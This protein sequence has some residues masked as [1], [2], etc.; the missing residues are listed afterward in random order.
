MRRPR[1][2]SSHTGSI[3]AMSGDTAGRVTHPHC[4]VEKSSY[5]ICNM[6]V[7]VILFQHKARSIGIQNLKGARINHLVLLAISNIRCPPISSCVRHHSPHIHRTMTEPPRILSVLRTHSSSH[8]QSVHVDVYRV[9]T[10]FGTLP[11]WRK[12]SMH[13]PLLAISPTNTHF[14][15]CQTPNSVLRPPY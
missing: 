10:L 5:H 8:Q 2:S 7:G 6:R 4:Y 14:C 3:G 9:Y 1:S 15:P 12:I 13:L 11:P